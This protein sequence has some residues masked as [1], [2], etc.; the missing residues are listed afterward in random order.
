[1][2]DYNSQNIAGRDYVSSYGLHLNHVIKK[3]KLSLFHKQATNKAPQYTE[4]GNLNSFELYKT[5]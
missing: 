3:R 1:M 2:A 4:F 5:L